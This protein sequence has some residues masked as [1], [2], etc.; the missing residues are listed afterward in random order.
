MYLSKI[1]KHKSIILYI[2]SLGL[3]NCALGFF[4]LI[5]NLHIES[6]IE[7]KIFLSNF[8][9]LGNVSMAL[10]G[11]IVGKAIDKYDKKKILLAATFG[12][13]I[14]FTGECFAHNILLLYLVS[15]LYG[16][17]FSLLMSIHIPFILCYASEKEQPYWLNISSSV[18]ILMYVL[19]TMIAGL[20][21]TTNSKP[22]YVP[23]LAIASILYFLSIFPLFGIEKKDKNLD[24]KDMGGKTEYR[25]KKKPMFDFSFVLI[26]FFCG[27]LIFLSPY[28]NLYLN[29][30][31]KMSLRSIAIVIG[32]IE[33]LPGWSNLILMRLFKYFKVENIIRV[34][35]VLGIGIYC[36]L[37]IL[38]NPIAQVLLLICATAHSSFLFPQITRIV[39][40]KYD[41][42]KIGVVSGFANAFYNAGD[43]VGTYMEGICVLNAIYVIPFLV[44]AAIFAYFAILSFVK[45]EF[46]N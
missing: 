33:F 22:I 44:A 7:N 35:C 28:M 18:K 32:I 8:Y 38:N 14:F 4:S 27:L 9:L 25:E 3:Y 5:F 16:I 39:I 31:Y 34:G 10:G 13:A 40:K 19:G 17:L 42:R 6:I 41:Q 21:P 12:A 24:R 37:G 29:N 20:I 11:V 46:R 15:I 23:G 36:L 26:F 43:A 2:T 30:R 45:P 1:A